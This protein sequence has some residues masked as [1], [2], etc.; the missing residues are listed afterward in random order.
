M[1][2]KAIPWILYVKSDGTFVIRQRHTNHISAN[3]KAINDQLKKAADEGKAPATLAH[4]DGIA[5]GTP[6]RP[7]IRYAGGK[8]IKTLAVELPYFRRA[9]SKAMLAT[10]QPV[11]TEYEDQVKAEKSKGAKLPEKVRE[12]VSYIKPGT[13]ATA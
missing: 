7:V 9:L 3:V 8:R 12:P 5:E 2:F 4:Y 13:T 10:I 6:A 1:G 11:V